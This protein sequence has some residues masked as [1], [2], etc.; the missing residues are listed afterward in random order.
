MHTRRTTG[1]GVV[2]RT[3]VCGKKLVWKVGLAKL[4]SGKRHVEV[5]TTSAD[6]SGGVVTILD[7]LILDP[8]RPG[9]LPGR[10]NVLK[11]VLPFPGLS[12][13]GEARGGT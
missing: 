1:V 11:S 2:R 5:V 10:L 6:T 9:D 3:D 4:R 13:P 7:A 8:A 12:R